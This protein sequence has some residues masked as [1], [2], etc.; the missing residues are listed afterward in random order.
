MIVWAEWCGAGFTHASEF[1]GRIGRVIFALWRHV[2]VAVAVGGNGTHV[3]GV[4][5][6]L[7][8]RELA[9]LV[10]RARHSGLGGHRGNRFGLRVAPAD[11][12]DN[13]RDDG[14]KQERANDDANDQRRV[15][16]G[17]GRHHNHVGGR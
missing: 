12:E 7:G 5:I 9:V 16:R 6:R 14:K 1:K 10:A 8:A 13:E 4:V 17:G 15:V 3:G 11:E 2:D